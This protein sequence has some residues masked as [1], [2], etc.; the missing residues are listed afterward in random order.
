MALAGRLAGRW[1]LEATGVH[2]RKVWQLSG[3]RSRAAGSQ[4][5]E[6]ALQTLGKAPFSAIF[7]PVFAD[8]LR[9]FS[10]SWPIR[11]QMGANATT[12]SAA[13]EPRRRANRRRGKM[14]PLSTTK[15]HAQRTSKE[16]EKPSMLSRSPA[17]SPSPPKRSR[18]RPVG[19][20][21]CR[22]IR[23]PRSWAGGW[24]D[25]GGIHRHKAWHIRDL[26]SSD[27]NSAC[28]KNVPFGIASGPSEMAQRSPK[29][30]PSCA[31]LRHSCAI[32]M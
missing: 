24:L 3:L 17:A 9:V 16:S 4:H 20:T 8:F 32:R 29:R 26:R 1:R 6:M 28:P 12:Q 18:I 21:V 30:G 23:H 14:C 7:R 10:A 31:S 11:S 2:R 25:R 13:F 27:L 22:A 5:G 19:G 15:Y